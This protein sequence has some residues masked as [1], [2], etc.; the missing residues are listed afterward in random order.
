MTRCSSMFGLPGW[1]CDQT[2]PS[3]LRW[4]LLEADP[5]FI[6]D[7]AGTGVAGVAL[8]AREGNIPLIWRTAIWGGR[9]R[10]R[11]HLLPQV[12]AGPRRFRDG[13]E[14]LCR[15]MRIAIHP[16]LSS[17]GWALGCWTSWYHIIGY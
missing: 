9:R 10:P 4:Y 17:S 7:G 16:A 1:L 15:V 5:T 8:V 2:S 14:R 3:D 11:G 12:A 6:R 13:G